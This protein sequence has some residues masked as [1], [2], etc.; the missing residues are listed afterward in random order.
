[1]KKP[2]D[3]CVPISLRRKVLRRNRFQLLSAWYGDER[4]AVEIS[5]HTAS[6]QS[7]STLLDA[8]LARIR[9]PENGM[10]IKLRSEWNS[11]VGN[12]FSRFT[13]PETLRDGILTLKVKHS[14]LLVELKPSCDII[15][16]KVNKIL[17]NGS[18]KEVRLR[19]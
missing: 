14:A 4:A 15:C 18:C 9:R 1:M 8:E 6:P 13:E 11:V 19:V 10:V 2:Q 17:G 3:I 12:M 5:A 16:A 7:I